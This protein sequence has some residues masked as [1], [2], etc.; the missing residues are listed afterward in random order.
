MR[1]AFSLNGAPVAVDVPVTATLLQVLREHLGLTGTKPGCEIGECGACSVLVNG[2]VVN[3]CLLLAPQVGGAEVVTVEGLAGPDDDLH[4]LQ[5]AF[6]EFGATQ[7]GYCV[8][9]MILAAEALLRRTLSPT[10]DEIRDAIAGNLCR[11]TG[12]QQ[13]ID[14]IEAVAQR[15]RAATRQPIVAPEGARP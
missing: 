12:Y 2:Q 1:V 3:A 6:L 14:L 5:R 15:R 10:R 8:P 11:C 13:I 9:G 4:D 7:C